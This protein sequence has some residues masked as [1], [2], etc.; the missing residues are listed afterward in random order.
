MS[1]FVWPQV[2]LLFA[3]Q[4]GPF[5]V[6]TL[7]AL[8][9][10]AA[11]AQAAGAR[12]A[13]RLVAILEGAGSKSAPH[14]RA[15]FGLGRR[16]GR[17]PPLAH[18]LDL[19]TFA[20]AMRVPYAFWRAGDGPH[21]ALRL[22]RASGATVAACAG[23]ATLWPPELLATFTVAL[24]VH[25]SLLPR[26]RG[27]APLFWWL[28]SGEPQ[29][30]VTVHGMTAA[31]DAGPVFARAPIAP[32]WQADGPGL[33]TLCG[34]VGG[35]LLAGLLARPREAWRPLQAFGTPSWAPRPE[36]R[37]ATLTPEAWPALGLLRFARGAPAL[38][39][40]RLALDGVHYPLRGGVGHRPGARLPGSWVRE[41][42]VL[43]VQA[44][45][46]V[47]GLHVGDPPVPLR[48][49]RSPTAR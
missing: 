19:Q 42:E 8:L 35:R 17:P 12:P 22:G 48:A 36:L 10:V 11:S 1:A 44:Q 13:Y 15:S 3:G 4:S 2:P 16:L 9:R 25:P 39:P 47:A 24:N 37:D 23:F 46:G 20:E 7:R 43:W 49:R 45:D 14:R 21:A 5:A 34:E 31:A 41:G 18:S 30:G 26:W 28:R 40:A 38:G 27:P 33:W 32:P 6:A 29:T